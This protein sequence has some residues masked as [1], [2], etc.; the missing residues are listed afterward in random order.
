MRLETLEGDDM[1][2]VAKCLCVASLVTYAVSFFLPTFEIVVDGRGKSEYGLGAFVLAF[3]ALWQEMFGGP[4][5]FLM[6]LANPAYWSG[7]VLFDKGLY[8]RAL[9]VACAAALLG[10]RPLFNPLVLVGYYVWLA[11]M[12]LLVAASA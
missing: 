12:T 5:A 9:V 3:G 2:R 1:H 6:W 10:S 4:M 7:V 11:G 8:G